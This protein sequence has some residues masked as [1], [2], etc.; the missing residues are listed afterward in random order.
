MTGLPGADPEE[1]L[2][3]LEA[4]KAEVSMRNSLQAIIE[5]N[6]FQLEVLSPM[7]REPQRYGIQV[8]SQWP[9]S[10]LMEF[11]IQTTELTLA[12]SPH[13]RT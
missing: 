12:L 4:V 13:D 7:G 5:H 2:R 11:R 10:S 1:E 6:V 3:W 9:W 8:I